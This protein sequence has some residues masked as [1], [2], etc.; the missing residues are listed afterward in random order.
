MGATASAGRAYAVDAAVATVTPKAADANQDRAGVVS[1]PAGA[2]VIVCD[3]VGAY[4]GSGRVAE[5]CLAVTTLHV[6]ATG[7]AAGVVTC[8]DVAADALGATVDEGATT[9]LVAGAECDGRCWF[10]LV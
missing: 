10:T 5:Q 3:G 6:L 7:I 4:S 8:A 9:L 1:T 2:A